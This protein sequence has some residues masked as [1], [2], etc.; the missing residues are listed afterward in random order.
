MGKN[1]SLEQKILKMKRRNRYAV[2]SGATSRFHPQRTEGGRVLVGE[3]SLSKAVMSTGR[4]P[5]PER[6]AQYYNAVR[7]LGDE[8]TELPQSKLMARYNAV[9]KEEKM[10]RITLVHNQLGRLDLFFYSNRN[11]WFFVDVDFKKDTFKRSREYG[12]KPKALDALKNKRVCWV[13]H[14]GSPRNTS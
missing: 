13:E 14:L 1:R 12:S 4:G 10:M 6:M 7:S 9:V 3:I 11:V 5:D 2:F 8:D